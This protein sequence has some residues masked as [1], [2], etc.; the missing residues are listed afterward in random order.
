MQVYTSPKSSGI[1]KEDNYS[2]QFSWTDHKVQFK[3]TKHFWFHFIFWFHSFINRSHYF[4]MIPPI[5]FLLSHCIFLSF[6]L[7]VCR[8]PLS[9]FLRL[10][11]SPGVP[12]VKMQCGWKRQVYTSTISVV[13]QCHI[14]A[15]CPFVW[16]IEMGMEAAPPSM[17]LGPGRGPERNF[18]HGTVMATHA[19]EP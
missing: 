16:S 10:S 11:L 17:A 4:F 3:K 6:C 13:S 7:F 19:N 12:L 18:Y 15:I 9:T 5:P 8:V 2:T 14:I 1:K